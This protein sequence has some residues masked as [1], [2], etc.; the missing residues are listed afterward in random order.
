MT[1]LEAK[2]VKFLRILVAGMLVIVMAGA[3]VLGV[4]FGVYGKNTDDW[5]KPKHEDSQ[6]QQEQEENEDDPIPVEVIQTNNISLLS[7]T[8]TTAADGTTSKTLTA[9]ITPADATNKKVDWSVAFKSAS[10]TWAKG[11]TV[12]DYVTITPTS[13]GALTATVT[14]KKA[15][16]EQIIITVKSR[17]VSEVSA[18][19]TVDYEKKLL[20]FTCALQRKTASTSYVAV[21]KIDC[22][23]GYTYNYIVTPVYSDFT[24]DKTYSY[25]VEHG[26]SDDFRSFVKNGNFGIVP[27]SFTTG[28]NSS[29]VYFK[30]G[31]FTVE[32]DEIYKL[33]SN[34]ENT[35]DKA[36]TIN[37]N[38]NY[39]R[40][41]V[42]QYSA[43]KNLITVRV[44]YNGAVAK[45]F[46]YAK[47]A[48][49]YSVS[50]TNV[51][52]SSGGL[53]F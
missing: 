42:T 32:L 29:A 26:A 2:K 6:G 40:N 51:A 13:D 27:D 34:T 41:A 48:V 12:T 10:S 28:L 16:G 37:A 5:F 46:N 15:F 21:D 8:A 45:T 31:T 23:A 33:L 44:S 19:A 36:I 52:L 4:G 49:D 53:T 43:G 30:G 18:T 22:S 38:R 50:V 9:T 47:G 35:A 24:K 3:I 20:D 1:K 25:T 7:S 17:E 11:K 14:C 39:I